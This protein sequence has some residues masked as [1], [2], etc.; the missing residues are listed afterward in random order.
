ME[1]H[2]WIGCRGRPTFHRPGSRCAIPTLRHQ[3][4][5]EINQQRHTRINEL[6]RRIESDGEIL[7][8]Q[9]YQEILLAF[10]VMSPGG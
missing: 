4:G 3:F 7:K 2:T 9:A 6:M 5:R 8:A 1:L 10:E